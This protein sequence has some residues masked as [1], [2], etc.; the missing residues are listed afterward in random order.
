MEELEECF[1]SKIN[2]K[3]NIIVR[4]WKEVQ[5]RMKTTPDLRKRF[6]CEP[7]EI[8]TLFDGTQ[9]T[10]SNQWGDNFSIFLKIARELHNVI[11]DNSED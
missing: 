6:F 11:D 9:I 1:P 8:I 2:G 3:T 4:D 10:I 7:D 5:R